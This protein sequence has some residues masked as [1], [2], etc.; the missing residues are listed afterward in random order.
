M[1]IKGINH[2][3]EQW[4]IISI[5]VNATFIDYILLNLR[6]LSFRNSM[7]IKY[8]MKRENL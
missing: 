3:I 2:F 4:C 5:I 7:H 6:I 8:T 1:I